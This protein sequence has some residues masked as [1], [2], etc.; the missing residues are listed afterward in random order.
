MRH[1]F[2]LFVEASVHVLHLLCRHRMKISC[3]LSFHP[4]GD[5]LAGQEVVVAV[6]A[7]HLEKRE[8]SDNNKHG[9]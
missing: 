9:E 1:T 3:A 2:R 8:E 5:P 4:P 6:H 7:S